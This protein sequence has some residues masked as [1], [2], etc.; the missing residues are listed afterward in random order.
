MFISFCIAVAT[1][2]SAKAGSA[3][4]QAG[5]YF[6]VLLTGGTMLQRGDLVPHFTVGTLQ[7]LTVRYSTIWQRRNLVLITLPTSDSESSRA[8]L[9]RLASEMPALTGHETEYVI[10]RDIVAGIACPGVVVADRWGE[11]VHVVAGSDVADLP[12]PAELFEW[13]TYLQRQC[14]ECQGETK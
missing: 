1:G 4:A 11:I 14:P 5:P 10:T 2:F 12:P 7:G 8:Y 3:A 13:V 6:A 9:S